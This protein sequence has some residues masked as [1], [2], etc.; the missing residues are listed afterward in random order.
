MDFSKAIEIDPTKG[1][2]F[3]NR[4]FALKK[5]N[6]INEAIQDFNECIR[7]EKTHFKAYYNRANCFEKLNQYDLAKNDYFKANEIIPNSPNTLSHI[8]ILMDRQQKL[9]EALEYFNK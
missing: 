4:G 3:H 9:Q 7:L 2:F 8:G 1:D 6:M 5:K